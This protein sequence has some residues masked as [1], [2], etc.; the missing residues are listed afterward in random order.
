MTFCEKEYSYLCRRISFGSLVKI[1]LSDFLSKKSIYCFYTS[2][3]SIF[4]ERYKRLVPF[5]SNRILIKKLDYN[6]NEM[7]TTE[8]KPLTDAVYYEDLNRIVD[9]VGEKYLNRRGSLLNYLNS[10]LYKIRDDLVLYV[11]HRIVMDI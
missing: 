3:L 8:G 1:V 6:I 2:R 4:I 9:E 10:K 7:Y 5:L 11:K